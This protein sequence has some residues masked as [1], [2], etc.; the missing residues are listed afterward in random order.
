MSVNISA[1]QLVQ[2]DFRGCID[3]ILQASRL[4]PE[5][6]CL[7]VTESQLLGDLDSAAHLISVIRELGIGLHIDDFGTGYSSMAYLRRLPVTGIKIDRSF[8]SQLQHAR[9]DH[10]I[11]AALISLG[12]VMSLEVIAEGVEDEHQS[13]MLRELRCNYGQGY[14]WSGALAATE[15]VHWVH[16][17]QRDS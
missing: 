16:Q 1:R 2:P 14:L 6:L 7:E 15:L 8:V 10:A 17:H 9:E 12:Q 3:D 5:R 13:S 4:T 11:V